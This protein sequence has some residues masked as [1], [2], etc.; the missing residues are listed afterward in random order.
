MHVLRIKGFTLVEAI[1]SLAVISL[2]AATAFG[3]FHRANRNA[4]V[5]RLYTLANT[6]ARDEIDRLQTVAPF[7]PQNA[8]WLGGAQIPPELMLDSARGGPRV[9][10]LP[11]YID[12][13]TDEATTRATVTTSITDVGSLATRACRVSVA[14]E[15][16]G[17]SHEVRMNTLRTSDSP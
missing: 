1:I 12:P 8:T 7:N 17:R 9:Q 6:L 13:L 11:L 2:M 15:F 10:D 16:A 5:A 14:F 3:A 4:M